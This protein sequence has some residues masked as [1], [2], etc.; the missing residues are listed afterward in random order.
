MKGKLPEGLGMTKEEARR[1]IRLDK[2]L[3]VAALSGW[4]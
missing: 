4:P 3:P 1:S 2:A